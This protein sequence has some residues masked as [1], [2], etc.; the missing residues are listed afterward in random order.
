VLKML[1]GLVDTFALAMALTLMCH[2]AA[3]RLS[4]Q[5]LL[6]NNPQHLRAELNQV[7][8]RP[9]APVVAG[10]SALSNEDGRLTELLSVTFGP[11]S[12]VPLLIVKRAGLA[13]R[14]PAVILLHG[15]NQ[16]KETMRP[17]LDQLADRG[18]VAVGM[19]AEYHG[20][21]ATPVDTTAGNAYQRAMRQAYRTG[22]GHPYLYDTAWEAT[23]LVDYLST[24]VDIDPKRIGLIGSSKGGTEAYLAA[25][26]D[27]RIAAV[28]PL[29]GVQSY[30]WSLRNAA[31]WEARTWT[32]R[33][34]VEGA[35]A[36]SREPV[37]AAFM[38]KFYDRIAPGLVDR[39]DGPAM[40]SLIAPRPMI[41]VNGDSDPRSPLGGVRE[42]FAAA[43]R[44]Y[45]EAG[46]ADRL[47]LIL[48]VDTAHQV[49]AEAW[50]AVVRWFERWLMAADA[51]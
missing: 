44:A 16:S 6:A 26:A 40:M 3:G 29:I 36:D 28:A 2:D 8:R 22:Q 1:K 31:A 10:A 51:G 49:S 47:A 18:F 11:D 9:A 38:K 7:I 39:F 19:D 17:R 14:Q 15:T 4:A 42:A 34:A 27:P 32:L 50:S 13:G 24:R 46:A 5:S 12:R 20:G 41:I 43:E 37:T 30:G 23:R 21:R 45:T 25:A 35:A 48:Q 33:E